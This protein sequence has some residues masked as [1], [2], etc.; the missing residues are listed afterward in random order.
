MDD[1]EPTPR[2]GPCLEDTG[3]VDEE[4]ASNVWSL[5]YPLEYNIVDLLVHEG[6]VEVAFRVFI[7]LEC[8]EALEARIS[9]CGDVAGRLM[10][11]SDEPEVSR[12]SITG[13]GCVELVVPFDPPLRVKKALERIG[14]TTPLHILAYRPI[15]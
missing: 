2:A 6:P 5:L 9:G 1:R 12:V 7:G 4:E 3:L 14:I 8:L 13:R 11:L 10:K 15:Q